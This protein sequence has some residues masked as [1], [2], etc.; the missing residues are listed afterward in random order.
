MSDEPKKKGRPPGPAVVL[1]GEMLDRAEKMAGY[2]MTAAQIASVL[3]FSERTLFRR[4]NDDE[5]F[6]AALEAGRAKAAESVG[7]ALFHKA[8]DGDVNAI[9]W[10][11][12]TR[13]GR[14]P[15]APIPPASEEGS[16]TPKRLVLEDPGEDPEDE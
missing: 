14:A 3:G 7:R 12:M 4:M 6:A 5:R 13:L 1:T 11:E 16:G 8:T 2:G 10:Y 9:K 15:L